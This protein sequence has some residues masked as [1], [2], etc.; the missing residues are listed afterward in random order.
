VKLKEV[1]LKLHEV[2]GEADAPTSKA[3]ADELK[4]LFEKA[5]PDYDADRFYVSHMK[6]VVDWYNELKNFASLDFVEEEEG[7][8]APQDAE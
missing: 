8:E 4:A 1:F 6:K 3:S 7:E 5:L 2:L